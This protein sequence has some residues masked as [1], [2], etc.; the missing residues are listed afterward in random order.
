VSALQDYLASGAPLDFKTLALGPSNDSWPMAM[1]GAFIYRQRT[2]QDC[3]EA[4]ALASFLYWTQTD[5]AATRTAERYISFILIT[6]HFFRIFNNCCEFRQGFVLPTMA[7]A[8][9][10]LFLNQLKNFTC[11]G[12]AVSDVHNCIFDGELCSGVGECV[13]NAC[14]CASGREGQYCE[15]FVA[16]S[17]S[18]GSDQALPIALGIVIP[19][20]ALVILGLCA[21]IVVLAVVAKRRGRGGDAWEIDYDEL[22]V[23]EQL[24]AGGF[25]EVRKAT[26]KG[27]EV[28]VKV[29]A[30]EK[31]TKDMEKN[32]KDEVRGSA[33]SRHTFI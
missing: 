29:M 26:W 23:G 18:A 8:I 12:V 24:G 6:L 13:N 25:G 2:M 10:R 20:V 1:F 4:A 32:F 17:S 30:S 33:F 5:I 7:T 14:V 15:G 16:A 3:S 9:K 21:L 22:E 31:I 28:A 11:G 27:T 19:L